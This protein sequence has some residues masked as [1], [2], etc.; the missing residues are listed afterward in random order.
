MFD[1]VALTGTV[2]DRVIEYVDHLH[3]H[4]A[5]PVAITN[6]RYTAPTTPGFSAEMLPQSIATYSY[7]DGAF[8]SAEL[9]PSPA[10]TP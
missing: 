6:G 4:F 8:W 5:T 9:T 7:P 1:Y 2:E 3:E 10:A